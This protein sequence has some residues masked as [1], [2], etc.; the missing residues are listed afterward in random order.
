MLIYLNHSRLVKSL[1]DLLPGPTI[2]GQLVHCLSMISPGI[3][4]IISHLIIIC[5]QT[6]EE[7]NDSTLVQLIELSVSRSIGIFFIMY[8]YSRSFL[9]V[10]LF[11]MLLALKQND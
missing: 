9:F 1:S 3:F 8:C 5:R 11:R 2:E 4:V 7:F 6:R 10:S